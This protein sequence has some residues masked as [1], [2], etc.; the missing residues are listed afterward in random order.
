MVFWLETTQYSGK[1]VSK[2]IGITYNSIALSPQT[3]KMA[4][5]YR[6][7]KRSIQIMSL[8]ASRV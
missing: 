3:L 7:N 2:Q 6:E 8:V 1:K 5:F 4:K